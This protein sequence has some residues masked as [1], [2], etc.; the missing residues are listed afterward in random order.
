[1][2][3]DV[4]IGHMGFFWFYCYFIDKI[5]STVKAYL[6]TVGSLMHQVLSVKLDEWTDEQ[7]ETVATMG[8]NTVVNMKYEACLP[9]NLKPKPES[10]AK[11]RSA[12]IK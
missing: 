11:E 1:M 4:N 7:V 3:V 8:G 9:E 5:C 6:I 2:A 12:Y 10:P